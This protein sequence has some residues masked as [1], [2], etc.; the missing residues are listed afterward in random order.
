MHTSAPLYYFKRVAGADNQSQSPPR[1]PLPAAGG[2][3]VAEE[4]TADSWLSR[5]A[6]CN[7][8]ARL[9]EALPG[10]DRRELMRWYARRPCHARWWLPKGADAQ[11]HCGG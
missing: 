3:A 10:V 4:A 6:L 11:S 7:A 2:P 1:T 8:D 5:R 9:R